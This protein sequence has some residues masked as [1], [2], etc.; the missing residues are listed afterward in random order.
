MPRGLFGRSV[1]MIVMPV[2]VL[3]AVVTY[4]LFDRQW[5]TVTTRISRGVAAQV[6]LFV[7]SYET[8]GPEKFIANAPKLGETSFGLAPSLKLGARIPA[9]ESPTYRLLKQ[10]FVNELGS[11]IGRPVWIDSESSD[12]KVDIRGRD[13]GSP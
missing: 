7:Q 4:L 10:V 13:A 5:E 1:I 9:T 8:L 3:Q 12:D 2:V 6:A 11:S